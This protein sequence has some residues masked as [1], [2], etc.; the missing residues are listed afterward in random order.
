VL[1]E[2]FTRIVAIDVVDDV[3]QPPIQGTD[4][5]IIVALVVPAF[6]PVHVILPK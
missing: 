6:T 3:L 4:E 1:P 5:A 2:Q